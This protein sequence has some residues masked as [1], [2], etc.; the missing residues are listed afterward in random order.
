[1][2]LKLKSLICSSIQAGIGS[3]R[4]YTI[5]KKVK[6]WQLARQIS[7]AYRFVE[8]SEIRDQVSIIIP[9]YQGA[10]ELPR[11]IRSLKVQKGVPKLEIMVYDSG[12]TDGTVELASKMGARVLPPEGK[13]FNHGRS[14]TY[15]ASFSRGK[16][17]VF[18]VQDAYLKT[19]ETLMQLLT[20]L[21]TGGESVAAVTGR[22]VPAP[23]ADIFAQWQVTGTYRSLFLDDETVF[24]RL[25]DGTEYAACSL[26]ARRRL[27]F[28]DNVFCAIR[29]EVFSE[30]GGF[31]EITISEDTWFATV[32]AKKGYQIGYCGTAEVVHSHTRSAAYFLRR[33]YVGYK[34]QLELYGEKSHS[35][36]HSLNELLFT[37]IQFIKAN[38]DFFSNTSKATAP[39]QELLREPEEQEQCYEGYDFLQ[40]QFE[41]TLQDIESTNLLEG[42]E[43]KD[44][45]SLYTKILFSL[46]GKHIAE[47]GNA[48]PEA[49]RGLPNHFITG[50]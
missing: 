21:A 26:L 5:R 39:L 33:Y 46:A 4:W 45:Q 48:N 15:A 29:K 1:M 37:Y 24:H 47:L 7:L 23:D 20:P 38:S 18:L 12:S 35:V 10:K 13:P 19:E 40:T 30:C 42:I 11:C 34:T 28:L 3:K 49:V 2:R 6:T 17:L 25:P 16:Y 36:F 44:L 14:R 31:P 9:T 50:I 22:Q 27:S 43:K 41:M 32:L 8:P